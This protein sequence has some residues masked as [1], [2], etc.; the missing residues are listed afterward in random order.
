MNILF[1]LCVE[2]NSADGTRHLVETYIVKPFETSPHNLPHPVIRNEKVFFPPHEDVF[3]LRAV[4]VVEIRLFRLFGQRPPRRESRPV[5]HVGFVCGAPRFVFC[6]NSVFRADNLAFEIGGQGRMIFGEACVAIS[7]DD[8]KIA[9]ES[10]STRCDYTF[11]AQVAAQE[12][13][14]HIHMLYV[15]FD[16]IRLSVRSLGA[17]KFAARP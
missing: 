2:V 8:L 12:R 15:D 11:D 10:S 4:L 17:T 6:L 5:L 16:I 9:H 1:A 14:I 13:F 7:M 3:S